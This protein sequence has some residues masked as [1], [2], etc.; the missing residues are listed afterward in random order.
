MNSFFLDEVQ[1]IALD[2]TERNADEMAQTGDKYRWVW[3]QGYELE[4]EILNAEDGRK[5]TFTFGDMN[6]IVNFS[7]VD[8]QTELILEHSGISDT[9]EGKLLGHLNCRSCWTFFLT[10]LTSVFETGRDLR[11]HNPDRT[12]SYEV[13]FRALSRRD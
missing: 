7:T 12:S 13:G 2:G 5:I 9:D 6:F 8:H 10:N 11:D 4:G 3:R 1:F